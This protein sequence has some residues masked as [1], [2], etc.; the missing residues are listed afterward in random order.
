MHSSI[1]KVLHQLAGKSLLG[2]VVDT[3][4]ALSAEQLLVVVGH[5]AEQVENAFADQ[6]IEFVTQEKQLGTGHAVMQCLPQVKPRNDLLVLYGDVPLLKLQTLENLVRESSDAAVSLLSFTP[7]SPQGYGRIVRDSQRQVVSIVEEKDA[8]EQQKQ[9][10]ECNTG[11]MLVRQPHAQ[12]LLDQLDKDNAQG[13]F[14]LTDVVKHAVN[15]QLKVTA[16]SC[17]DEDEVL[18]VNNQTQLAHLEKVF[19]RQLASRLL[20]QGVKLSDPERIDIRGELQVGQDVFIDSNCIFEGKVILSKGV[21]VGANCIL[22]DCQIGE[23]TEILPMSLIEQAKIGALNSIGPFARIRPQTVTESKVKIGNFVEIKK[24]SIQAGS[25]INHL[26]Y[27]GD[28]EMGG[29]VNI[30]AGTITCNYDGANKHK[31]VIE[32]DVFV[33]SDTQLVAPVTIGKGSTIGAG[34][35][36]TKKTPEQ[37]L[38]LSRSKQV[39]VASWVRPVKKIKEAE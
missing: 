18:G 31:T 30:G 8:T 37:Q 12:S 14:Y 39:S 5:G 13:E 20:E 23:N 16:Q 7:K 29:N 4:K 36:I 3:A 38:S 9:I 10:M 25:K 24:S 6:G 27:I 1:P 26:S 33:G 28:T 32:D 15:G 35:T 11:I 34:S 2:H 17:D 21:K 19:R 22:R